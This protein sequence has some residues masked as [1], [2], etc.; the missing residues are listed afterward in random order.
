MDIVKKKDIKVLVIAANPFSDINNNGKTLKSIFSSLPKDSL[1]ELYFRPQDNVIA[2]GDFAKSFYAVSELDIARSIMTFSK[3][4]GGE[5][6]LKNVMDYSKTT[7]K[8]YIKL[9]KCPL[10][11]CNI[12]RSFLWKSRR[13]DNDEFKNWYKSC[14]PDIVFALLGPPGPLFTIAEDIS[15][16]LDIPLAIYFTDDYL[17]NWPYNRFQRKMAIKAFHK[18]VSLSSARFCIGDMMCK[19]YSL[20][21]GKDFDPI[22]NSVIAEPYN[23][24]KLSNKKYRMSYFGSLWLDRW[25]M[26]AKISEIV[27]DAADIYIYSSSELN[28]DM[29]VALTRSNV[30]IHKPVLGDEYKNA[31]QISDV[32]LHVESDSSECR[33]KTALSV[34]TKIP[35]YLMS[36]KPIL[37]YGPLEVASLK[38]LRDNEI[39]KVVSSEA[40]I[41]DSQKEIL[42]FISDVEYQATLSVRAHDY[43]MKNFDREVVSK[44]LIHKLTRVVEE[45]KKRYSE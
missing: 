31:I 29:K 44:K 10:K 36:S 4:C 42:S 2:D 11:N 16:N 32:L 6:N 24:P 41:V 15:S 38:L 17:I 34:S 28:D 37:A 35:E 13:W 8:S 40:D 3:T 18:I 26:L 5:Q 19:E 22:M 27:G 23:I 1:F 21:F 7:Q 12:L 25:K 33:K 39:A 30:Y 43:A 45:H 9:A 20:L 14:N